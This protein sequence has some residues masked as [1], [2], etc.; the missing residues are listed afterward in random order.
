MIRKHLRGIG[1]RQVRL[2]RVAMAQAVVAEPDRSRLHL[3]IS[4]LAVR[5]HVHLS[6]RCRRVTRRWNGMKSWMA[7]KITTHATH[8]GGTEEEGFPSALSAS[9]RETTP[10][11]L[12]ILA[13]W[14]EDLWIPDFAHAEARR[15]P[16]ETHHCSP[17]SPACLSG[18]CLLL[19]GS[20]VALARHRT[21]HDAVG[22]PRVPA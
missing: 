6:G 11:L 17:S 18:E 1:S 20:V 21:N 2:D 16:S 19:R 15:S 22:Y 14:R 12:R 8:G 3:G 13:S 7:E 10:C 4:T 9:R 5:H